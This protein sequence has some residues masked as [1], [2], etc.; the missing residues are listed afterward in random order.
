M[1]GIKSLL[2][3]ELPEGLSDIDSPYLERFMKENNVK[4][5]DIEN[6]IKL[7]EAHEK[8]NPW[9]ELPLTFIIDPRAASRP[10]VTNQGRVYAHP[11]DTA[12]KKELLTMIAEMLD[13]EKFDII[14]GE[15]LVNAVVY[16]PFYSKLNK[17]EK[18]LA[19]LGYIKPVNKP[20]WD[21]LAKLPLDAFEGKLYTNDSQV[22]TGLLEKRFSI[23]PRIE[24]TFQFQ[25]RRYPKFEVEPK[26]D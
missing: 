9:E 10:R 7:Y 12:H 16:R 17:A 25:R 5:R 24:L 21:N 2:G 19:E 18:L 20:D 23:E 4:V 3:V 22:T 15:I 26:K 6:A 8:D 11:K 1:S 13:L 14:E